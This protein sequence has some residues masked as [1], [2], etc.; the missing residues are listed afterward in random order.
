M[1][2][3]ALMGGRESLR[4]LMRP[5]ECA[6]DIQFALI[7]PL[8]QRRSF[9]QLHDRI[10]RPAVG[11]EIVNGEDVRMRKRGD[12]ARLALEPRQ[13]IVRMSIAEE[14]FDGDVALQTPIARPPHL[15]HAAGTD[16][17]NDFVRPELRTDIHF[18]DGIRR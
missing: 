12:G 3:P 11:S 6:R 10:E 16:P 2:D 4:D 8:A 7:E 5:I 13:R 17:R 1:R 18:E 9:E 15:A 14:D